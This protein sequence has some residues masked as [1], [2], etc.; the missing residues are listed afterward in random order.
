MKQTL[1]LK[2]LGTTDLCEAVC[3]RKAVKRQL[4]GDGYGQVNSD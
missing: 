2:A 1:G 4:P 3:Q